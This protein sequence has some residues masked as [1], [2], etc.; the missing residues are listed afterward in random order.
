MPLLI[1]DFLVML[2]AVSDK[3]TSLGSARSQRQETEKRSVRFNQ[4]PSLGKLIQIQ[5]VPYLRYRRLS[6]VAFLSN[7]YTW[8][9]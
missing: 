5:E 7:R 2:E 4:F 6:K 1:P 8:E 9:E 3:L